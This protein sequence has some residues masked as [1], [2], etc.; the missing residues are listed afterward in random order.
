MFE[1]SAARHASEVAIELPGGTVVERGGI[2]SG[3]PITRTYGDVLERARVLRAQLAKFVHG[4]C[5]VAV[6][7][8]KSSPDLHAAQLA[9]LQAGAAFLCLD[10]SF[11]DD[12]IRFILED[13]K[14]VAVVTDHNSV[15]RLA[16]LG[17]APSTILDVD[18]LSETAADV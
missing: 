17:V 14:A 16:S 18:A 6:V 7:L 5:V 1:R 4:E 3:A 12:H 8:P 9:V 15:E 11:P 10:L 13:A 2:A